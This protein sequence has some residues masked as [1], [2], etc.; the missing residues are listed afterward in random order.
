KDGGYLHIPHMPGNSQASG[1]VENAH[2]WAEYAD[3]YIGLAVTEGQILTIEDL[4]VFADRIVEE[5]NNQPHRTTKQTPMARWYA[6]RSIVR[7]IP[8][9]I[10]ESA[11]LSDEF[12]V[13]L[14]AAMTVAHKGVIY[15]V[16]GV[17][18]FVNYVGQKVKIVVP[19]SIELIILTLPDGAEFEIEKVLATADKAGEFKRVVDSNA[20]AKTKRLKEEFQSD[21]KAQK[22]KTRLTGEIAPVPFYNVPIEQPETNIT[23]F[24]H[25]ERVVSHEEVAAVTAIPEPVYQGKD[26]NYWEAVGIYGDRFDGGPVEAKEFLLGVFPGMAGELPASEVEAAIDGR[27]DVK[28][29]RILRAV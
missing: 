17:L 4:N 28:E 19:P 1:K 5:K 3:R 11:L 10:I 15:R 2:K 25:A 6:T 29:A 7:K 21:A 23:H 12:E 8:A 27:Y 20:E 16:P 18:P 14:D 24:P 13:V 26:I 9:E 22:Q